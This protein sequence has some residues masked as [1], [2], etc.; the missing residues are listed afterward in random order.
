M[1]LSK[2]T[3]GAILMVLSMAGFTCNDALVKSVTPFMN[4]GQI[5]L[6]R[7]LLT[8]LL[9]YVI[10]RH[11]GALRHIRIVAQPMVLL[12]VLC[13]IGAAITY[14][15][16]LGQIPLG[17]ASSILQSLPLAVTLGAALVLG[18]SVGWRR[19]AA[20]IVGFLGVM[21]IIRPGPEGFTLAALYVVVSVFFAASRDLVTKRISADVPSLAI[22]LY[23]TLANA[24][25]GA[26]LIVPLGGW[27]PMST[28]TFSHL[29]LASALVFVGYQSIVMAMRT[30]EI[31]FIAPFRYTSLLWALG[32]GFL[33][34]GERPDAWTITGA[35]VV[36]GSG[37]YAFYRENQRNRAAPV[38]QA[39]QPGSPL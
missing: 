2:N 39:S 19:W 5:M 26:L 3:K 16:A 37:L 14:L 17:N 18:E 10:A 24:V 11:L 32:L 38:A 8:F 29:L 28:T 6:V 36:I 25:V 27:Q 13:E 34:F 4:I 12:R 35:V 15:T 31:S 1:M 7:G 21:I 33:L 22:T 20:I 30:G 23:T 9:V